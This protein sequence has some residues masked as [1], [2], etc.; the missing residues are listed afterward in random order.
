MLLSSSYPFFNFFLPFFLPLF[1]LTCFQC[2][3]FSSPFPFS[4]QCHLSA[5]FP[6]F[7]LLSK[8]KHVIAL[9]VRANQGYNVHL[10]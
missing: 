2:T 4:S 1:I 10:V 6:F 8:E 3:T 9:I 5:Q 7:V